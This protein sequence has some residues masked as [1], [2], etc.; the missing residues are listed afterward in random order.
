M[1]ICLNYFNANRDFSLKRIYLCKKTY[2][3]KT[4]FRFLD[5]IDRFGF[6]K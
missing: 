3:S 5:G 1:P 6:A 2:V 4:S